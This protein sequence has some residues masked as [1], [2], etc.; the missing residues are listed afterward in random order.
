MQKSEKSNHQPRIDLNAEREKFQREENFQRTI[1][2][3][4]QKKFREGKPVTYKDDDE[5]EN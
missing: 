2:E 4:N 3:N 5:E 1:V